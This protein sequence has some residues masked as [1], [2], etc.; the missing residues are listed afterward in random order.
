M[1]Q[2]RIGILGGSGLYEIEGFEDR[3]ETVLD[4]PFGFPSDAFVQGT[5]EGREVV[6]LARHGRGHR[7]NPSEINYRANVWGMRKLGEPSG[8]Q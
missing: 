6:F 8:L 7:V 4:T 3:E 5:L 1:G 2:G